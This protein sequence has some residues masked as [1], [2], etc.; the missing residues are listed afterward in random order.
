MCGVMLGNLP[1]A[2][3]LYAQL[4]GLGG[5]KGIWLIFLS[6]AATECP[7]SRVCVDA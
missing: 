7:E 4:S 3:F 5:K 2:A 6:V 1:Q